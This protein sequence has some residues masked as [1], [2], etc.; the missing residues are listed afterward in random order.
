[1]PKSV[2]SA[3][4]IMQ[5]YNIGKAR[6]SQIV[7]GYTNSRGVWVPPLL[8]EGVDYFFERTRV[9][10]PKRAMMRHVLRF[11]KEGEK[12]MAAMNRKPGRPEKES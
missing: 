5:A 12:K 11:T 9:Q 7:N 6:L 2:K 4:E 10:G 8:E 1:M 3:E